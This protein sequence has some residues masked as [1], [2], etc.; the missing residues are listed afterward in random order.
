ME[1]YILSLIKENSRVIVPNFGAFIV[2]KENGFSVLFN[3][4]LSFNDGLLIDAIVDKEGISKEEAG[5]KIEEYVEKLKETLDTEGSYTINDLGEFKK[6]ASGVVRF[7]QKEETSNQPDELLDIDNNDNKNQ[8]EEDDKVSPDQLAATSVNKTTPIAEV[9]EEPGKK[10]EPKKS[11]KK[12][13][14]ETEKKV[15]YHHKDE[16]SKRNRSIL[17][18]LIIFV[19]IPLLGFAIYFWFFRD[20]STVKKTKI[21]II[22]DKKDPVVKSETK[23]SIP[24]VETEP[25][26]EKEPEVLKPH[27]I[28]VG[29][30]RS[31][32][33]A[34]KLIEDL[35]NK[36]YD[37]CSII[38]HNNRY[39]V[40]IESFDRVY[41]AHA[42]QEDILGKDRVESWILTKR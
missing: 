10:A 9:D 34:N 29:S 42:R 37:Q 27:H 7:E 16:D 40:S 35:N 13:K 39:L 19:L 28:I 12:V 41:K 17:L 26:I 38:T 25:V 14:E 11:E 33:L 6:D 18:F 24:V 21:E 23:E 15:K 1:N 3:N 22:E 20:S 2:A 4:F 30:F 5:K 31:E 36:G 8:V 32:D